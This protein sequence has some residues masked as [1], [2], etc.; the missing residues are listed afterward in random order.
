MLK[1]QEK[2]KELL[3][4]SDADVPLV[5]RGDFKTLL[6]HNKEAAVR[7]AA[8][9]GAV[10]ACFL[11]YLA[12]FSVFGVM[13]KMILTLI[14][15]GIFGL[16]GY[17]IGLKRVVKVTKY[18]AILFFLLAMF[19]MLTLSRLS[20][21]TTNGSFVSE[22]FLLL[23]LGGLGIGVY[24]I[25]EKAA[26]LGFAMSQVFL[27]ALMTAAF[28]MSF[29]SAFIQF[30]VEQEIAHAKQRE[31]LRRAREAEKMRL[32]MA[33]SKPCTTDEECKKLN[34]KKNSY[35]AEHE[36][37]AQE[38]CEQAV[39]KEIPDRFE[40]TVGPKEYKFTSYQVDVL[41][42]LITLM[43]DRAQLIDRSGIRTKL[44][45]T[46]KYNVKLKTATATV[47]K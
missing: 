35:Y 13:M 8:C 40:W 23:I 37:V 3:L 38:I 11:L 20:D 9:Y 10:F 7:L 45:Y 44:N 5:L 39:S 18:P 12:L 14:L 26:G 43:G 2:L 34:T 33:A 1:I 27:G 15:F 4:L 36:E 47:V 32:S 42:D 19:G 28:A 46:C 17:L 31:E 16:I 41:N 21:I 25:R 29:Q 24:A 30:G 6:A 22:L